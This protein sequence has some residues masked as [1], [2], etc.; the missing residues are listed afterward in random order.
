MDYSR[1]AQIGGEKFRADFVDKI[2]E[3]VTKEIAEHPFQG[4]TVVDSLLLI[5]A[6]ES[7]KVSKGSPVSVSDL[8]DITCLYHDLL[9]RV[10]IYLEEHGMVFPNRG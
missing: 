8:D 7:C 1:I 10:R 3:I 6:K 2:N 5:A 9:Y 4:P